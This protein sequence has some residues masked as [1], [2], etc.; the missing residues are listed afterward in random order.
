MTTPDAATLKG[1]LLE[2]LA[3]LSV[4]HAGT[5]GNQWRWTARDLATDLAPLLA[6]WL[7]RQET[8]HDD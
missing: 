4:L 2:S 8:M 3:Y 7:R 6:R 1:A 5:L